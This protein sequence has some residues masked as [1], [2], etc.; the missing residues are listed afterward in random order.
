M[1]MNG[2]G[3][4]AGT[5]PRGGRIGTKT[6]IREPWTSIM[7]LMGLTGCGRREMEKAEVA[8]AKKINS[9]KL[10]GA[11]NKDRV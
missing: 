4:D 11:V 10:K 7:G 5:G 1:I 8:Q 9:A 3:G 6:G 2:K